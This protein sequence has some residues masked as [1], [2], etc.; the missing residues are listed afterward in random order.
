LLETWNAMIP[1]RKEGL[2]RHLGVSNF[3]VPKLKHLLENSSVKPEMNQVEMHPYLI[4]KDLVDFAGNHDIYLT[5]YSPLGS[6]DRPTAQRDQLPVLLENEVV[7]EVAGR[8]NASPAQILIAFQLHRNIA[9]IPKSV[10][11]RR[12]RENYEAGHVS[13]TVEDVLALEGLDEGMRY[14][15]GSVWT[16]EGSPYTYQSLWEE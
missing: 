8:R 2:V 14:L 4:Q 5:A 10:H 3:N 6:G 11:P 12:I 16:R 1:I 15:N 13:L 9:V 7:R